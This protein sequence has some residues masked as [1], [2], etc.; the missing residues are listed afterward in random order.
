MQKNG[1]YCSL[2][3]N[4]STKMNFACI[5]FVF[6]LLLFSCNKEEKSLPYSIGGRVVD[7]F[8]NEI[9]AITISVDSTRITFSDEWGNWIL[10]DLYGEHTIT[11]ISSEFTFSPRALLVNE[12]NKNVVFTAYRIPGEKEERVF[13]WF[14]NQQLPNGTLESVENGN[15]VSLYDNAL[16][17]MVFMLNGDFLKA[18]RIF[19]F[20]ARRINSELLIGNGGFS[21]FRDRNGVPKYHRWMGDNAWL[22][23][24]LNNY[25]SMTGNATYDLLASEIGNWL[26]KLQDADGGL[27]AGYSADNSLLNYKVTEGNI[28]AFNAISGYTSFHSQLLKFLENNR[29]DNADNNLVAWPDNSAYL[30][31]LDC[32][33]WSY[34][35]FKEYPV[36]ALLSAKRFLT[37]KTATINNVQVNGYDIDEDRDAVFVEGTGQMA[38]AFKVAG[39]IQESDYYL[40]EMEKILF[41][42]SVFE[43]S[44]GFPY[45][46]NIG[47]SYGSGAL[48]SGA[49]TNIAVSGG[50]WYL[51]AKYGFNPFDVGRNKSIPE[52]DMF[53]L[54]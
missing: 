8:N 44:Y 3:V 36:S 4:R 1:I 37:I 21:Q 11:P 45:A 24:A 46:T 23:I 35:I 12:S 40:S 49:D 51:F 38:L 26:I 47:T 43:N 17:A 13:N 41:R 53:W 20:F 6:M 54:D 10:S 16:A 18:E 50:A 7:A 34:C 15:I 48:W 31:A 39:L 2:N 27:F 22:L 33:S 28:D 32:Q 25:K 52:A 30:Y 29:W 19:D 42:S 14:N 9:G 5:P